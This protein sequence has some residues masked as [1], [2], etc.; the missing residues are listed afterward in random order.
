MN[1]RP[2]TDTQQRV[3]TMIAD[4]EKNHPITSHELMV[5]LDIKDKDGKVGANLRS[6]VNT[7]RD[8]G[9]PVCAN[10]KGY[11]YPQ[12]PE[13][14]QDYIESFQNRINQQQEACNN[15]KSKHMDWIIARSSHA[16]EKEKQLEQTK[17]II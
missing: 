8:K 17:L 6:V 7:L 14:L 15:L 10:G 1:N 4:R 9:F 12:T 16:P 3:L 13:E 5:F 2:L 11:Y